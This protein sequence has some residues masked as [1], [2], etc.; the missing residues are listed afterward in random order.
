MSLSLC[1]YSR[2]D[3]E[4]P[5]YDNVLLDVYDKLEEELKRAQDAGVPKDHILIDPGIGFG[6]KNEHNLVLIKNISIFIT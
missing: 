1:T 5:V 4:N 6:K 2:N 3:G